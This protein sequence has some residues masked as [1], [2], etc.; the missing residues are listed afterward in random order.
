M[1]K[2][3]LTIGLNDRKAKKQ[4]INTEE[5]KDKIIKI[6][7]NEYEIYA[8]TTYECAG[9]YKHENGEIVSETSLRIEFA[10]FKKEKRINSI[11]SRFCDEFNQES[12]MM[13]KSFNFIKFVKHQ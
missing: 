12:I 9:N 8:F 13:E 4:L 6:L 1:F 7:L 11:A 10:T 3:Q 2:Y 5:A